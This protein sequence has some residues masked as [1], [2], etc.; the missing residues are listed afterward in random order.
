MM[1]AKIRSRSA[2]PQPLRL[3]LVGWGTIARRVAGLLKARQENI[4]V[5]GIATRNALPQNGLPEGAR[6]LATPADLRDVQPDLVVEAASSAAVK[7]WGLESLRCAA[8][9][10]V[11]ST[12]A[13]SDDAVLQLLRE[14]AECCGS[15]ILIPSGALA[16]LD[17]LAAASRLP[18]DEVTHC[19]TKPPHAWKGTP[20]ESLVDLDTLTSAYTFFQGSARE[21]AGRFPANANVAAISAL[22]GI[23]FE[24]TSVTLVAD[25]ATTGNCHHLKARGDFGVL[26]V[27]IENRPFAANPKSSELAALSLVRLIELRTQA[28]AI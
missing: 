7:P 26:N 24:R 9:F 6:W 28:M 11:S 14:E 10:A 27:M 22:A 13:F 21:A 5:V 17:A 16:G 8:G 3:A 2:R 20:A 18:I 1:N 4:V 19:I 25:P 23:G 15:Q 12:S